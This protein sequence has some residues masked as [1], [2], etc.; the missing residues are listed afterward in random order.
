[1]YSCPCCLLTRAPRGPPPV[2]T[3]PCLSAPL[4]GGVVAAPRSCPLSAPKT[5]GLRFL[6]I[7]AP[8]HLPHPSGL[9]ALRGERGWHFRFSAGEHLSFEQ[10]PKLTAL[11]GLY[12]LGDGC[13]YFWPLC[14]GCAFSEIS[15]S[16]GRP[17]Q[18]LVG[19]G[20]LLKYGVIWG[21][22]LK[23]HSQHEKFLGCPA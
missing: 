10:P 8:P 13:C 11:S 23:M 14:R 16:K 19:E 20:L 9:A 17:I 3:L 22:L 12:R 6:M 2:L 21:K 15:K 7:P 5:G 18:C 4:S 1:M